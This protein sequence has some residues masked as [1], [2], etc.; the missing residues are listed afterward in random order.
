MVTADWILLGIASQ[1]PIDVCKHVNIDPRQEQNRQTNV[2]NVKKTFRRSTKSTRNFGRAD[3]TSREY[4]LSRRLPKFLV[5]GSYV[6]LLPPF[7][8]RTNQNSDS[9][10]PIH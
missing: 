8:T 7:S 3:G 9:S 2:P 5:V 6:V 4:L 10:R 1:I